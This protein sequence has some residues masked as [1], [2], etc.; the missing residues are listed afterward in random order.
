[1]TTPK[2]ESNDGKIAGVYLDF[3]TIGRAAVDRL[4]VMLQ[5]GERGLD[6]GQP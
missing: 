3:Q 2:P 1:M 6:L 4:N 5:T